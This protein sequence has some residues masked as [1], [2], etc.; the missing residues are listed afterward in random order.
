M[1]DAGL[2]VGFGA[3]A[4]ARERQALEQFEEWGTFCSGLRDQGEIESFEPVLLEPHGGDLGGFFLLRG[5]RE[6][7]DRLRHD[8]EFRRLSARAGLV[9]EGFGVVGA[10]LGDAL[11]EQLEIYGGQVEDQLASD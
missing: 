11:G 7:L 3:P 8:R 4:R 9:V 2:F 5:E 1:A 6:R 10:H